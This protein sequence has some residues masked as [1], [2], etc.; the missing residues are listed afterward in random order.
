MHPIYNLSALIQVTNGDQVNG[1]INSSTG[2]DELTV[3]KVHNKKK[4]SSALMVLCA[5]DIT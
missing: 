3:I 1:G 2:L 5:Q 4:Q